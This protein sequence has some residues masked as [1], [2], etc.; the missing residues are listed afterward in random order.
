[1]VGA[2]LSVEGTA[3]PGLLVIR[4]PVH[5]DAR[6]W[7]KENWQRE[8]MVALGLPDFEPVQNNISYNAARGATRGIHAE[9]WDKLVAVGNG[10]VFAAWVDLRG[11]ASFGTT[12]WIEIDAG[13]VVFVPR[14]V[15][16]SYQAL[17][18][19]TTY[20]YLVNDHFVAGHTYPAVDLADPALAIP[21]PIPLSDAEISEKDRRN[22]ALADVVPMQ[23]K[24][25]LVLGAHGQLGRALAACLPDAELVDQDELDLTDPAS[26]EGWPW[27]EYAVVINAAAYTAV[28]AA[29]TA[30]GRRACWL[31][32]AV[33]PA[34]LARMANQHRFTLVH[35]SSDYVFDG[36]AAAY[37]EDD[38]V[39]PLGVYGQSKAAGDLAVSVAR[40]HYLIRTSWVIGDGANFVRTMHGLAERGVTPSVVD[41]QIGRLTFT[42]D[43]AAAIAH[44]IEGGAD[45][46]TYNCTNDG[47]PRSWFDYARQIYELGGHDPSAVAPV[48]TADYGAGKDLSPRPARSVLDLTKIRST[49]WEPPLVE[50]RLAAYV[51]SL[52]GKDASG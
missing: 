8:K 15:A 25:T 12:F 48:S 37:T 23:P 9:P 27:Q 14:G 49:G 36:T 40:R 21:W 35:V 20:T 51:R 41:D 34:H 11:G 24:R 45:F 22:P 3:I 43:L 16:N 33:A 29:E 50:D 2:A 6:G 39:C 17:E 32:N 1:M 18:D 30:E 19:H 28:D 38:P 47:E 52:G 10:R 5:G 26:V 4:L 7:F 13:I 31:A 42:A 44:L 46:G